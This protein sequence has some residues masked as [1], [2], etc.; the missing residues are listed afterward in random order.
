[1]TGITYPFLY[2]L[3][4]LDTLQKNKQGLGI[5]VLAQKKI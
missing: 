2:V 1:M 4:Q 3:T 5:A